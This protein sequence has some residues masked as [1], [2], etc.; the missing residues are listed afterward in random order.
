VKKL[1]DAI[2]AD[3]LT[4]VRA[5]IEAK[6]ELVHVI[7]RPPPK[8]DEGQQQL[9]IAIKGGHLEIANWLIDAGADVSYVEPEE[10]RA[11]LSVFE[12]AL[13]AVISQ[14][15][16]PRTPQGTGR[17]ELT[18]ALRLIDLGVST[19]ARNPQ[20]G[21]PPLMYIGRE[22]EYWSPSDLSRESRSVIVELIRALYSKGATADDLWSWT[23]PAAAVGDTRVHTVRSWYTKAAGTASD[24]QHPQADIVEMLAEAERPPKRGP[25]AWL[26]RR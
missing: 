9:Q 16:H 8:K 12:V 13:S 24:R 20:F 15:I 23:G 11:R 1:F 22:I 17:P 25:L 14:A 10:N 7:R 5:L 26:R 21:V 19:T 6:P 2:R 4:T 3:D 18:I